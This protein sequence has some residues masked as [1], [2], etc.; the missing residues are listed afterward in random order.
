MKAVNKSWI[1]GREERERE[2]ERERES[3]RGESVMAA[4]DSRY[5]KNMRSR[6]P[7][8]TKPL[9]HAHNGLNADAVDVQESHGFILTQ[10]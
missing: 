10:A 6:T 4:G 1:I 5:Q 9:A 3:I 8:A 7:F 2:R